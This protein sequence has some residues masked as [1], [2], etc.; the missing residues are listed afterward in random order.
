VR[1]RAI[2]EILAVLVTAALHFVFYDFV[3][4]RLPFILVTTLAWS[5]Y[6]VFR[7]KSSPESLRSFGLSAEGLWQSTVAASLVLVVGIALCLIVGLARGTVRIVPQMLILALLYPLWGL[8]QQLLV[9]AMVVRNLVPVLSVPAV[10][11]IAG[12]LFG[13]V[14]LPQIALAVS[15]ALLGAVFTLIFV[16]W[17]NVWALGVCHGVLG[18]FF[19][20]W[21]LGRDPWLEI[22]AGA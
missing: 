19:Y 13:I 10:V 22:V 18:V 3:P 12:I 2:L 6:F 21:V 4:G 17:R 11:A 20:F 1:R 5:A 9:Q 15:T 7:I 14:H 8:V 16:R